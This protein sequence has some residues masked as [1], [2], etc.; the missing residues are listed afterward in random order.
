MFLPLPAGATLHFKIFRVYTCLLKIFD[1]KKSNFQISL[2]S[3]LNPNLWKMFILGG[4]E[5]T[6][7]WEK[8]TDIVIK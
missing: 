2:T 1:I 3:C 8:N 4:P 5:C 6:W 7:V